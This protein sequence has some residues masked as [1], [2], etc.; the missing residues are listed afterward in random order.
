M[1]QE[2]EEK[3][4]QIRQLAALPAEDLSAHLS[5]M[6][7]GVSS[8][9]PNIAPHVQGTAGRAIQ[10]LNSKLPSAGNELLQDSPVKPSSAQKRAWLDLHKVV[11]DPLIILDHVNQGTINR[12]HVEALTTIYP[13]LHQELVGK[14]NEE[15]GALRA[16][17]QS[18][19]YYKRLGLFKITG[20]PIDSTMTQPNMAAI[21]N[22][23]RPSQ[24]QGQ[25]GNSIKKP[26]STELSQINKVNQQ[27]LTHSQAREIQKLKS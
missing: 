25:V 19:P 14:I 2:Y 21:I 15:L 4:G 17:G 10:F 13:N 27:S 16:K 12:H 20:Q 3:S 18:L 26:S 22:A 6:H 5:Q 23:N 11:S 24:A 8:I 1:N 7:P 9:A